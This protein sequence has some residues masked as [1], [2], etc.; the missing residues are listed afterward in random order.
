MSKFKDGKQRKY[1]KFF[2]NSEKRKITFWGM[3]LERRMQ[4]FRKLAQSEIPKNRGKL[5]NNVNIAKSKNWKTKKIREIFG[6]SKKQKL[7]F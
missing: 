6:N 5:Y 1:K 7:E 4:N 2:L 3:L